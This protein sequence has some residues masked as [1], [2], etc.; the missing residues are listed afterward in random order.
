MP[1]LIQQQR[2]FEENENNLKEKGKTREGEF[3][4]FVE[5]SPFG[6]WLAD[7]QTKLPPE[8]EKDNVE[9][10]VIIKNQ[11]KTYKLLLII[12]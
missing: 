2:K 6:W 12:M 11:L 8:I 7:G 3:L 9:Y 10:K 5:D 1:H 4:R